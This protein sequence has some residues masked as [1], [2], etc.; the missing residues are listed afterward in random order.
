MSSSIRFTMFLIL[1]AI[2]FFGSM[3]S[4][5]AFAESAGMFNITIKESAIKGNNDNPF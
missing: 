2:V 3:V 4:S 5:Y 1:C